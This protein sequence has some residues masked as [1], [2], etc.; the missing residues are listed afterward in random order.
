MHSYKNDETTG[1]QSG[2][3]SLVHRGEMWGSST[4]VDSNLWRL[5]NQNALAVTS[6][7]RANALV[8]MSEGLHKRG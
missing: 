7:H 5:M 6:L 3:H 1:E 8:R 2:T 4:N